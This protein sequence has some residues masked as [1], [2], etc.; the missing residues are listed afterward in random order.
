MKRSKNIQLTSSKIPKIRNQLL[1]KQN[2][3]CPICKEQVKSPCLD[4]HHKSRIKGTGLVRGVLC[5]NCNSFIAKA[6]NNC[7]RFAI[8]QS[9]LPEILRSIADY[10]ERDHTIFIHPSEKPKEKKLKKSSYNQLK[11]MYFKYPVRASFPEYPKSG[12]LIKSLSRLFD[13]YQL[14]PEFYK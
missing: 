13:S 14:E 11:K 4:H 8:D 9:K 5:R 2:W 6:E 1:E 12:K 10:L 3:I 7:V